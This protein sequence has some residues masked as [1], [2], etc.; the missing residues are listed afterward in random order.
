[1]YALTYPTYDLIPIDWSKCRE[2]T[3]KQ[4]EILRQ[5]QESEENAHV[6]IQSMVEVCRVDLFYRQV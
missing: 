6:D 1:M 5:R 2:R 3:T 4:R